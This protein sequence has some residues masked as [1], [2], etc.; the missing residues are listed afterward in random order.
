M[1]QHDPEDHG[2]ATQRLAPRLAETE[3][4][5]GAQQAPTAV[6]EVVISYQEPE[7]AANAG[8]PL[9]TYRGTFRV[10]AP[11]AEAAKK[12]AVARFREIQ[13]QSSVGWARDIV[14][15]ACSRVP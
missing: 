1:A 8:L 12:L 10:N 14:D 13:G 15:I 3:T 4:A 11:D 9:T 2:P 5:R 6:Y 7:F